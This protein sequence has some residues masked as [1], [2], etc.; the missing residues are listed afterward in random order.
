M[1]SAIVNLL[2]HP[3]AQFAGYLLA[4]KLDLGR[5][6]G[7]RLET[8]PLE[9]GVGPVESV[10]SG[11][12]EFGVASPA[13][14]LEHNPEALSFLLTIQ[15]DSPLVYPVRKDSGIVT[16]GDLVG[17]KVGIWPGGEDLEFRWMLH[18][19]GV[20]PECVE[21]CPMADT[22]GPFVAGETDCAQITLYNELRHISEMGLRLFV[23][24]AYGAAL[25]KDG[26]ICRRDL[27]SERP[28]YV[29]AVVDTV[30]AGWA[31][32]FQNPDEAIE[33]S[34]A[35]WPGLAHEDQSIQFADIRN[36][37]FVGATSE[38]G[39]GYPDPLH[40]ERAAQALR[41]L[42]QRVDDTSVLALTE[43]QFWAASPV[44]FKLRSYL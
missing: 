27:V 12:S 38:Q 40:T 30:M 26:L 3:Q 32:A 28:D 2:W 29:Q 8:T 20:D 42:G 17:R 14:A 19:A 15:Q 43:P 21:R 23:P 9:F 31:R 11:A 25:I 4:E 5:L 36:L 44:S 35:A 39:L 1:D 6:H 37:T 33:I 22:V 41:D 16:L 34:A 24:S 7:V 13:H 18:R 10:L